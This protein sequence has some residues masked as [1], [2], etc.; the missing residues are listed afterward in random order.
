MF[1][2]LDV[3]TLGFITKAAFQEKVSKMMAIVALENGEVTS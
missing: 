2:S 3:N 1:Y